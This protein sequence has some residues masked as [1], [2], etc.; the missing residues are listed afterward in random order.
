M[1]VHY[2][3]DSAGEG[4]AGDSWPWHQGK[5]LTTMCAQRSGCTKLKASV[6]GSEEGL[7]MTVLA[8]NLI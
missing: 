5:D 3:G 6:K 2:K 7:A 4:E 1:L 8:I